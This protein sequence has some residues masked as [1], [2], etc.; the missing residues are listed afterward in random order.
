M[1]EHRLMAAL[2][3]RMMAPTERAGLSDRRRRLLASATG[4][5]LELGAGTG[6]NLGFY[7]SAE[8]LTVVEPDRAMRAKLLAKL[9]RA[10]VP[11]DIRDGTIFDC[12]FDSALFD[13]VVMTLVLCTVDDPAA[14][15]VEVRRVLKPGG[16]LLFLEH[17]AGTGMTKRVQQLV[18]P[19]W[20]RAA[21]G[22]RPD[23]DTVGAIRAAGFTIDDLERFRMP[24]APLFVRPAV[25]GVAR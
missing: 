7:M 19:L 14:T 17:V 21:G 25:Q 4:R 24:K 23:R 5:V 2:Y 15:L 10:P 20:R 16:R 12:R 13:T 3:D 22:C 8:V 6:V 18:E 9:P 11:V 1:G